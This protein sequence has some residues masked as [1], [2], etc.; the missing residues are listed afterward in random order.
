MARNQHHVHQEPPPH[1]RTSP[2]AEAALGAGVIIGG[3]AGERALCL[4]PYASP[5][6][7][8]L[9]VPARGV[10]GR[11]TSGSEAGRWSR[12]RGKHRSAVK[13]EEWRASGTAGSAARRR[14]QP[15]S[16]EHYLAWW[17]C[18]VST[19]GGRRH[20]LTAEERLYGANLHA[21][22]FCAVTATLT[23]GDSACSS[24]SEE[25]PGS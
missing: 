6:M 20:R 14:R 3:F 7:D 18:I 5:S 13:A 16:E 21:A 9:Q 11:S 17:P 1:G 10:R 19:S 22:S 4:A 25:P 23:S 15:R 24:S 8:G 12:G 2:A